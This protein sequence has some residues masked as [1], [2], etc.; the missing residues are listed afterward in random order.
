MFV[1]NSFNR[2]VSSCFFPMACKRMPVR[3]LHR[4]PDHQYVDFWKRL[5]VSYIQELGKAGEN[6]YRSP[7]CVQ[8][9]LRVMSVMKMRGFIPFLHAMPA[10]SR[11]PMRFTE[12]IYPTDVEGDRPFTHIRPPRPEFMISRDQVVS[13]VPRRAEGRPMPHLLSM[14]P[15]LTAGVKNKESAASFGFVNH[16]KEEQYF[17]IVS[18]VEELLKEVQNRISFEAYAAV[19]KKSAGLVRRFNRLEVGDFFVIGV[20]REKAARFVYPSLPYNVPTGGNILDMV[21][22][23]DIETL[24]AEGTHM[25]T[26]LLL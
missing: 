14:S 19:S 12:A 26:M 21:N 25:A 20:P 18:Q 16:D 15:A 6:M 24:R 23:P 3:S 17:P 13:M 4:G 7:A 5:N 10:A 9:V 11:V 1:S 22:H 2:G 8:N